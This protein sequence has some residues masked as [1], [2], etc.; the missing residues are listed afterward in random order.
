MVS[1]FKRPLMMTSMPT[2][3]KASHDPAALPWPPLLR[4]RLERRYQR[5]LADIVLDDGS[6]ITA[7][8][9][10]SGSMKTCAEPGRPVY[11]SRQPSPRRK[12]HYTWEIID[13]GASLVGVNTLVPNRLVARAIEA[14]AVPELRGYADLKREAAIPGGSR[15][16]L[17]L[18]G[19][20]RRPCYV[21]VKNCTLADNGAARFP[22]AATL[23]GQ[24]H[25]RALMDLTAAGCRCVSFFLVQRSDTDRFA[26]ADAIDP[27]YGRLLREA[28]AAGVAVMAHDVIMDTRHIRLRRALPVEL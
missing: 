19:P 11:V 23:R 5:F 10:N 16:D 7:H 9:P 15:L 14:G 1:I 25:L 27:A 2:F 22:D 18:T 28:A 17:L 12:L 4:G 21:E 8:C 3:Q 24:K 20:G 26:P 13:M 6:P